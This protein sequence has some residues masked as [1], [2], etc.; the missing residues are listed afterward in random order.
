MISSSGRRVCARVS[1][2]PCEPSC[3]RFAHKLVCLG[4]LLLALLAELGTGGGINYLAAHAPVH[5]NPHDEDSSSAVVRR[6]DSF[7]LTRGGKS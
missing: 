5:R 6:D 4:Q 3:S 7:D 2:K 1:R